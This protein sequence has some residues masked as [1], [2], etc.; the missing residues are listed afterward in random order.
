MPM[1]VNYDDGSSVL[2][3]RTASRSTAVEDLSDRARE[4]SLV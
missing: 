2:Q 4:I 1:P 3:S